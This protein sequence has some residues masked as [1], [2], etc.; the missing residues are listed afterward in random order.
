MKKILPTQR[1]SQKREEY[2]HSHFKRLW[3]VSDTIPKL[4]KILLK[5]YILSSRCAAVWKQKPYIQHCIHASAKLIHSHAEIGT[6]C[7]YSFM[8]LKHQALVISKILANGFTQ[9]FQLLAHFITQFQ[10]LSFL[11]AV[12][13]SREKSISIGK[14]SSSLRHLR[15][16]LKYFFLLKAWTLPLA[17]NIVSHFPS[18]LCSFSRKWQ[19]NIYY[20]FYYK[21]PTLNKYSFPVLSGKNCGTRQREI[22]QLP[23]QNNHAS[24][25]S[26][27][28][29]FILPIFKLEY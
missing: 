4:S 28:A 23:T 14:L 5:L 29:V 8:V 3:T 21:Y 9:I 13:V 20:N 10:K 12:L 7:F 22:V 24:A 17:T 15:V 27:S 25:W 16:F 19:P 18:T 26:V 2:F 1:Q 6:Y 11:I